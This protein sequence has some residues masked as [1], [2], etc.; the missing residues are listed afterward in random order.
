MTKLSDVDHVWTAS[1]TNAEFKQGV[2]YASI[3]LPWTFDRM[4]MR[5]TP[6]GQRSRAFNIA[7]GI[8]GQEV[9]VRLLE[10]KGVDIELPRDSHRDDDL[11]D[12]LLEI[13]NETQK[14]DLKTMNYF[15]DY[16]DMRPLFSVDYVVE[17]R[18]YDGP[19]WH[20]FFPMM[21]P[22]TQ[23]NQDKEAYIFAIAESIDFREE[24]TAGRSVHEFFA[25]PHGKMCEFAQKG[26]LIEAREAAKK[27]IFFDITYETQSY[28]ENRLPTIELIGEWDGAIERKT[29]TLEKN[30]TIERIGPFSALNSIRIP[31]TDFRE[32]FS[33]RLHWSVSENQLKKP[34]RNTTRRDLNTLPQYRDD[35]DSS[36]PM[37]VE[38]DDFCNLRLPD[39]YTLHFLGWT[40]KDEFLNRCRTYRSWI[41]PDDEI[42]PTRNQPW[43]QLTEDDQT[44]L[45]RVNFDDAIQS[46][47]H[48][49][50]AG[51]LKG[52]PQGGSAATYI[53]P[54][55]FGGG[56][57]ETNAYILPQD[58]NVMD[59]IV[60][61]S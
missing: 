58:L 40:A 44:R 39:D 11:F 59:D 27:G 49:I 35:V 38:K 19:E 33:G 45:D 46:G 1:P 15:S 42:D 17:N 20:R 57:R 16:G 29:V 8:V 55:Q 24:L 60:S 51:F 7:K 4:M 12:I 18:E 30:A 31:P 41:W 9:L 43:S 37:T 47:D 5:S 6:N 21:I 3:S 13:D 25:F 23:L 52:M 2:H 34:V 28:F 61:S 53:Y 32:N 48:R 14:V 36:H 54:N 50:D 10:K 22:H 56:L 26:Q